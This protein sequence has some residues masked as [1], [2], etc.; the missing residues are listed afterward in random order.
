M[1]IDS[2][3]IYDGFRTRLHNGAY[4]RW[5][6]RYFVAAMGIFLFGAVVGGVLELTTDQAAFASFSQ[7]MGGSIYPD[8][9]TVVTILVNNLLAVGVTALGLVSF[10]VIA[11]LS[12]LFN[13]FI[14]GLVVAGAATDG[15]VVKALALILP[16][17]VLELSMFWLVAAVSFRVTHRFM[18]YLRRIDETPITRQELF[19]IGTL[20]V[21]AAVGIAVAAWI[22]AT[23][24]EPI[25]KALVGV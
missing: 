25:A 4:G 18:N 20:L 14:I 9:L 2:V 1:Q 15:E 19:E 13:G 16:H 8:R 6:G 10:G 3:A 11:A 5:F 23:L 17:G 12:L 7:S 24:T 22:E 21:L